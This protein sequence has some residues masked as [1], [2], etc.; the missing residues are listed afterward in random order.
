MDCLDG[1]AFFEAALQAGTENFR[2]LLQH[3]SFTDIVLD[4]MI[5]CIDNLWLGYVHLYSR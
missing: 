5:C 4:K 2:T 3:H 1:V